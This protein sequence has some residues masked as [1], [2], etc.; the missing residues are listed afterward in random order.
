MARAPSAMSGI[1]GRGVSGD[2]VLSSSA[3]SQ[4]FSAMSPM[5]SRSVEMRRLVVMKRRSRAA[6]WWS[7]S[8]RTHASSIATSR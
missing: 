6:G 2:S 4:M 7:A 1:S 5:R 8:N 3:R